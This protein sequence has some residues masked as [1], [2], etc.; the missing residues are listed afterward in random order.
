[1]KKIESNNEKEIHIMSYNNLDVLYNS[2]LDIT[3]RICA[4]Q[5]SGDYDS[6]FCIVK[7]IYDLYKNDIIKS[8]SAMSSHHNYIG[9]NLL[10]TAEVVHACAILRNTL[11]GK[12][13]VDGELLVCG[14][15]L[16]DI[17]KIQCYKT[18]D[19]GATYY[20]LTGSALGGHHLL[21]M[22]M[23]DTVI[24]TGKY[25]FDMERVLLLKNII[26]SHHGNRAYGDIAEP[27]VIEAVWL[28]M[29]DDLSAKTNSMYKCIMEI[30][31]GTVSS[32]PISFIQKHL[33]RRKDQL[34]IKDKDFSCL[35]YF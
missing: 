4:E 22:E 7:D 17:G 29:I 32:K 28:H 21:S 27:M 8:S 33:Y 30:E 1:M 18:D 13:I 10:H 26:A 35:N 6:L 3:E 23:L 34:K 15:A 9:G 20:T 16:H 5:N 19:H 31:R 14:A 24:N 2:I 12:G 11:M 25:N